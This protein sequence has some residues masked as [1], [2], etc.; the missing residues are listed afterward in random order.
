MVTGVFL[1]KHWSSPLLFEK[2]RFKEWI[3]LN[4]AF[5]S[6][7]NQPFD[8]WA[9]M[10]QPKL[11]FPPFSDNLLGLDL[12]FFFFL[13]GYEYCL[14]S[15]AFSVFLGWKTKPKRITNSVRN[16]SWNYV[17]SVLLFS[18]FYQIWCL[19]VLTKL[20]CRHHSK[21]GITIKSAEQNDSASIIQFI[22]SCFVSLSD[23]WVIKSI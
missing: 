7:Y 2:I 6:Y 12:Q 14:W 9:G 20:N 23:Y 15:F 13:L 4:I 8:S 10:W 19:K 17:K 18:K 16:G 11:F 22:N 1:I 5:I 21:Y 3:Y